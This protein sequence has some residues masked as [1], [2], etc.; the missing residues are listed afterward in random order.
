VLYNRGF[1]LRGL[2]KD[3]QPD[4]SRVVREKHSSCKYCPCSVLVNFSGRFVVSAVSWLEN[5]VVVARCVACFDNGPHDRLIE[6]HDTINVQ[7]N[8]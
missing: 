7:W 6:I 4:L 8:N 2:V 5:T 1:I 3:V